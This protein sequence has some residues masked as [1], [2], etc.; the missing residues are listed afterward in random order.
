MSALAERYAEQISADYIW[1]RNELESSRMLVR[2]S[3]KNA[4]IVARK[5]C[6]ILMYA[7]WEGFA[8][9][10]FKLAIDGVNEQIRREVLSYSDLTDHLKSM[11]LFSE[12][13][14]RSGS[15]LTLFSFGDTIG[16]ALRNNIRAF[17][18]V[19][20]L[21]DTKS[22]LNT[23]NLVQMLYVLGLDT[24]HYRIKGTIIDERICGFRH[25]LAHGDHQRFDN[26]IDDEVF[27]NTI[28]T[29]LGLILSLKNDLMN[30]LVN[31]DFKKKVGC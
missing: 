24:G 16:S 11:A 25:Q 4:R 9:N 21:V 3:K 18:N 1:R 8:K 2:N 13:R 5:S 6:V 29:G 17:M 20:Y 19:S 28:E 31:E 26:A 22:N 15:N 7:H 10:A 30:F 14:R 23:D 27:E 12:Y